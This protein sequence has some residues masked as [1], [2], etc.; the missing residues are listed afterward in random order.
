MGRGLRSA[1]E[2]V[3]Q[4]LWF[5]CIGLLLVVPLYAAAAGAGMRESF[6]MVA[7]VSLVVMAWSAIFNTVFDIIEWRW[8]GRVA[9][10]RPHRLRSLHA[11]LHELTAMVVSCPVIYAMTPL[12]WGQA[13]LADLGLTLAYAAYAYVFHLGY[14]RLRPVRPAA[15]A[16]RGEQVR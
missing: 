2:R 10:H 1:R 5:E 7:V 15:P 8:T 12:G 4:T 6:S 9:S 3:M 13:L 16:A 14:D 11:L